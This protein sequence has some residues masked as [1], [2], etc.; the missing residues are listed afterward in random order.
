M[1]SIAYNPALLLQKNINQIQPCPEFVA[2]Q[3]S[4][5]QNIVRIL[6]IRDDAP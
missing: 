5:S 1:G 2:I 6:P 3:Y 4:T